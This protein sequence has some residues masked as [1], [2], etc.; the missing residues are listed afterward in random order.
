MISNDCSKSFQFSIVN[1]NSQAFRY[2]LPK[3]KI[4]IFLKEKESLILPHE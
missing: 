4:Q 1:F 2:I 3:I